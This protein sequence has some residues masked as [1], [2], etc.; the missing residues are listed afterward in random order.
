MDRLGFFKQMLSSTVDAASSVM[1]LKR[2]AE[3]ITEAVDDVM[4]GVQAEIGLY[5][6]SV[7]AA[8]YDSS[9]GTLYEV[10]Q[11]GY[12]TLEV[13]S[14]YDGKCYNMG[15]EKFKELVR[16]EGLRISALRINKPYA[17]PTPST[18]SEDAGNEASE[19]TATAAT[20]TKDRA[21]EAGAE[22]AIISPSHSEWL[23][24]AIAT[25]KRLGCRYLTMANFP[26]E[27]IA[28]QTADYARYY[29]LIGAM[30][31]EREITLC[32][33]PSWEALREQAEGSIF[34][35]IWHKCDKALVKLS[36]DTLECK[37]AGVEIASLLEANKGAVATLHIHDYGIVGESGEIDFD[38]VIALAEECGTT[39]YYIE[40]S[41]CTLPPMKCLERSIYHV[42]ALPSVK[43]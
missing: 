2:A 14:Y 24:K 25:A 22:E 32:I 6:P 35:Q 42:E 17:K 16:R 20:D 21:N 28:E 12:T 13:G 37:R 19:Q 38:K 36:L 27:P 41:R 9:S 33:H 3:E 18:A 29:N 5:L 23:T 8:M 4:R 43:Y 7:D 34:E 1:G 31:R 39:S 26:D 40:V 10:A 30:C 11:M 15:A